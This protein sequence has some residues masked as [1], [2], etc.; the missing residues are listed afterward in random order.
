MVNLLSYI[1]EQAGKL[2]SEVASFGSIPGAA[3]FT[4][5]NIA[6]FD[7]KLSNKEVKAPAAISKII[8]VSTPAGS[9]K[10]PSGGSVSKD[11]TI[12]GLS[13]A[14]YSAPP[15]NTVQSAS[16]NA[17]GPVYSPKPGI[18]TPPGIKAGPIDVLKQMYSDSSGSVYAPTS[19]SIRPLVNVA[20]RM[21]DNFTFHRKKRKRRK[22][23]KLF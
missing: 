13:G 3:I 4:A 11:G 6:D 19:D 21:M 22:G 23:A 8:P 14:S 16:S 2:A 7:Q 10:L 17:G 20:G 5:N 12:T 15:V 9:Y 1:G 18:V